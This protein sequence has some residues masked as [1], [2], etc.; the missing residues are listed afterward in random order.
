MIKFYLPDE[1]DNDIP[2]PR[3][4]PLARHGPGLVFEFPVAEVDSLPGLSQAVIQYELVIQFAPAELLLVV[5]A[6]GRGDVPEPGLPA[7]GHVVSPDQCHAGDLRVV[8]VSALRCGTH[9]SALAGE[10]RGPDQDLVI[11][12][13]LVINVDV[14]LGLVDLGGQDH[15]DTRHRLGH[16]APDIHVRGQ[17]AIPRAIS[18]NLN[19]DRHFL[20][21]ILIPSVSNLGAVFEVRG[22][23]P[24]GVLGDGVSVRSG[25]LA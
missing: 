12:G 17:V 25:D 16:G 1:V 21:R 7:T 9:M 11:N 23:L 2:D 15:V 5:V 18:A 6:G 22:D 19:L 24:L 8:L 20:N 3:P 13:D 14:V 4:R 10:S